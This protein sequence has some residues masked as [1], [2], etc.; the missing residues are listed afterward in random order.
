MSTFRPLLF[1]FLEI[2][3]LQSETKTF[4]TPVNGFRTSPDITMASLHTSCSLQHM[5]DLFAL[6]HAFY[7]VLAL[8]FGDC[9]Y[10]FVK[11]LTNLFNL[12]FRSDL[13]L[14]L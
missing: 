13:F 2:M 9:V 10:V 6:P 3:M 14:G 8:I 1:S 11:L 7:N 5:L 4:R 12:P